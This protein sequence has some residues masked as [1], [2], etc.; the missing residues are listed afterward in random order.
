VTIKSVEEFPLSL[1]AGQYWVVHAEFGN[2]S[3]HTE[4]MIKRLFNPE[5]HHF[6]NWVWT[7]DLF[8]GRSMV[9]ESPSRLEGAPLH[10]A[11]QRG[12]HRVAE[13]LIA[14]CSQDVNDRSCPFSL[15]PLHIA[16]G[17]G[18]LTMVQ[19]LLTHHA[20]VNASDEDGW[21][22]LHFASCFGLLKI[23]QLLLEHGADVNSKTCSSDTP[24]HFLSEKEGNLEVAQALLEHGADPSI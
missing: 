19:V 10:Y 13:W 14:T 16:S 20:D 7:F 24:L 5:N 9:S 22:P 2:V 3:S 17:G 12:F 6:V 18:R 11:A 1:Y 23:A 8:S 4:D 15:T 21:T